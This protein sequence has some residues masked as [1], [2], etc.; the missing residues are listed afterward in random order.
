RNALAECTRKKVES[1]LSITLR[2]R[3]GGRIIRTGGSL[4]N[5]QQS[6]EAGNGTVNEGRE[7]DENRLFSATYAAERW[8]RCI[9][10]IGAAAIREAAPKPN[11]C[12]GDGRDRSSQQL[13]LRPVY[14]VS[15]LKILSFPLR[16]LICR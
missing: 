14:V 16:T 9:D 7:F 15:K 11:R 6:Y 13:L 1:S 2:W 4:R 3:R 10:G 12:G 5:G 8:P